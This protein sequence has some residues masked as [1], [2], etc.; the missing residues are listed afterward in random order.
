MNDVMK[1]M[2]LSVLL[3]FGM[4][5]QADNEV[6]ISAIQGNA[7]GEV[8]VSVSMKNTD[9]VSSLQ[10]SIPIDN[11]ILSVVEGSGTAGSRCSD[12]QVTVGYKDGVLNL[13]VYSLTMAAISG[14]SGEV[15]SFKVKLGSQPGIYD[16]EQVKVTLTSPTGS[17]LSGGTAYESIDIRGAYAYFYQDEMDFGKVSIGE[18]YIYGLGLENRGNENLIITGIQFSDVTAFS[19]PT[20]Y[21][22]VVEPGCYGVFDVKCTPKKRGEFNQTMTI[23]CN[24]PATMNTIRL[25]GDAFVANVLTVEPASGASDE[26]VTINLTMKN[27]DAVSG[28]QVEFD[29]PSSL[30]YVDGSFALSNRKEDHQA[31]V[32]LDGN[33]LRILVYSPQDKP[34]KGN[35]GVIGTFK[36]KLIGREGTVLEPSKA[37]L[38]ATIN[39]VVENVLSNAVGGYVNI[40]CPYIQGDEELWFGDVPVTQDCIST[41][42]YSNQGQAPL[43][44]SRVTFTNENFSVDENLP[45]VLQPGSSQ[46]ITVRYNSIEEKSFDGAVMQIHSNDPGM[47]MKEVKVHGSRF[48]PNYLKA[49]VQAV[50]PSDNLSIDVSLDTYD[51]VKGVQFD[52][53]YPNDLYKTFE[54]FC[55]PEVMA[56]G[57]TVSTEQI[58][59]S[60]IRV[61]AYFLTDGSIAPGTGKFMTLQLMPVKGEV[62]KGAYEITIK[63]IILGTEKMANKYAGKYIGGETLQYPFN[64]ADLISGD[65]N[66]DGLVDVADVVTMI[67]HILQIQTETFVFKNA[68]LNGD[69]VIDVFDVTLAINMI[70][71]NS[72]DTAGSRMLMK[73]FSISATDGETEDESAKLMACDNGFRIGVNHAERFTAFQFEMEVPEGV[74]VTKAD[75]TDGTLHHLVQYVKTGKNRYMVVGVSMENETLSNANFGLLEIGLSKSCQ[76]N[77]TLSN[78]LFVTPAGKKTFFGYETMDMTTGIDAMVTEQEKKTIYDLSGRRVEK[79]QGQLAKGVYIINGKKV[80][81]K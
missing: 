23:L 56:K 10:L 50:G 73:D 54:G 41:Y 13:F 1:L 2:L 22:L 29:M 51:A 67:N 71:A 79:H 18:E 64:V 43:T 32:S 68:D 48:A 42:Y 76:G 8:T 33:H 39:N 36:V 37:I 35:A 25:K 21:P 40:V 19:S 15:A 17:E 52:M 3:C 75:L 38:S 65:V 66:A 55:T 24:S 53:V 46:Y 49:E 28:Y 45:I 11:T 59:A 78:I 5:A 81:I 69:G 44:I 27:D 31:A 77:V 62:P 9:V 60:T 63:N 47:R 34:F 57:M 61:L 26:N 70:L 74:E 12:H 14:N 80:M 72:G 30:Q 7:G 16:L 4:R 58:D 6:G 20:S